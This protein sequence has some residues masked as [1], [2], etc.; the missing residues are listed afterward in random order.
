M[1]TTTAA[2][3]A[4]TTAVATAATAVTQAVDQNPNHQV[5]EQA[6][7]VHLARL[8]VGDE[9]HLLESKLVN[10]YFIFCE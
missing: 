5:E 3:L 1:M 4:A 10:Y 9:Q 2:A 8:R 6:V 7:L